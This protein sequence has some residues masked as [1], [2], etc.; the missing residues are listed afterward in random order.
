MNSIYHNPL[1]QF[2]GN[3][4]R[5][6]VG[7]HLTLLA[8]VAIA[9]FAQGQP[10]QPPVPVQISLNSV[11]AIA[12][13]DVWAVGD[14]IDSQDPDNTDPVFEHWDGNQWTLV[15]GDRTLEDQEILSGSDAVGTNDVWAVGSV[16][17]PLVNAR[18][19]EI[20]HWDGLKWSFVPADQVSGNNVLDGVAVVSSNDVWAVG[21]TDTNGGDRDHSLIEHWDG[22]RWRAVPI[23]DPAG[24]DFL[25]KVAVVSANDVWA[26]GTYAPNL[27]SLPLAMHWNGRRWSQIA[28]PAHPTLSTVLTDV[29]ALASNDVWAVGQVFEPTIPSK[30]QVFTVHWDGRAWQRVQAQDTGR[31]NAD[32]FATVT[33]V[34][35]ND[36]W[37]IG[38]DVAHGEQTLAEHWD[39]TSWAIVPAP[40]SFLINDAAAVASN[41]VWA[42]GWMIN[43]SIIL[44]W[45]GS[46][47]SIVPS[48]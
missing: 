37:A 7:V 25:H 22:T 31:F 11:T 2:S 45:N 6:F 13:N 33:A 47:W 5:R 8:L 32:G 4:W 36:I 44:H 20:E 1:A 12:A 18:Q 48:P 39:G 16:G 10:G 38:N 35:P 42:V 23:P 27:Q 29:V 19:I 24:V 17:Q 26:I 3:L 14:G 21:S 41:D 28:V 30:S 46:T 15:P 40:D 34:A 9:S 43:S